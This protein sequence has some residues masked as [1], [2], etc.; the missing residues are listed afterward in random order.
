[1]QKMPNTATGAQAAK[2]LSLTTSEFAALIKAGTI[3]AAA[4]GKFSLDKVRGEFCVYAQKMMAASDAATA[5]QAAQHIHLG[6]SRFRDL[7]A[8]GVFSHATRGNYS[9]NK[10]REEYCSNATKV[11]A[12]RAADGGASLSKQRARLATAQAESAE[13]KNAA[14]AGLLVEVKQV[15]DVLEGIIVVMR[16]NLLN[17][18]GVCADSLTPHTAMDRGLIADILKQKV[19][20]ILRH[21]AVPAIYPP[22]ANCLNEEAKA[23]EKQQDDEP[24]DDI[25]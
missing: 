24:E 1:M 21:M 5:V 9:L 13:R 22:L 2:H 12:G 23:A 14:E 16:E 18:P 7:V 19:Y 25:E 4:N 6:P 15:G 11:M 20:G 3:T 8:S 10:V 17:L